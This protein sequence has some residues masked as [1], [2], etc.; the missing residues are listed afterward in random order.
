MKVREIMSVDIIAVAPKTPFRDLWK[1]IIKNKIHALPVIDKK[2]R[3]IGIVTEED[4]LKPLYPDYQ[5]LIED[6]VSST[7]FEE[8][9]EKVQDL[10]KL[11]AEHVMN[12]RVI[13]TRADTPILRALSR[14]IVRDVHQL[15]V[16]SE[17]NAVIGVVS[18]GDIFDT[19]FRKH[20][21]LPG[22]RKHPGTS[23]AKHLRKNKGK[24]A[25]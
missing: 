23:V 7:N 21:R 19:L 16:L 14:M 2:K 18:K 1:A 13:F 10:V 25:R 3:I 8:M 17:L 22:F 12:K 20:L 4:L 5:H 9:E 11:R 24:R 6:F 15:P